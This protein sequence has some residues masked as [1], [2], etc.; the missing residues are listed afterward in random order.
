MSEDTAYEKFV[1]VYQKLDVIFE[2]RSGA[3]VM[4]RFLRSPKTKSFLMPPP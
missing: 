2:E 3:G 4:P 1:N